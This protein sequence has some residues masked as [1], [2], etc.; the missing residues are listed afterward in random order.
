MYKYTESGM[1]EMCEHLFNLKEIALDLEFDYE[2][3]YHDWKAL[4]Q[5]SKTFDHYREV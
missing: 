4:I 2:R 1:M 5:I 3:C